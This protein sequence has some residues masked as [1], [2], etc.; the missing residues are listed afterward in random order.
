[1]YYKGK[2]VLTAKDCEVILSALRNSSVPM[3]YAKQTLETF[4]KVKSLYDQMTKSDDIPA[5]AFE[6]EPKQEVID[7]KKTK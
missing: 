4:E 2:E 1:M 6:K 7:G 5:F 3:A